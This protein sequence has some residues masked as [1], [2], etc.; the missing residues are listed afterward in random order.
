MS[1]EKSPGMRAL[2][3]IK[4]HFTYLD[5]ITA[6]SV[7]LI[8]QLIE[9]ETRCVELLDDVKNL[10]S[11]YE[12]RGEYCA[13]LKAQCEQLATALEKMIEVVEDAW[14]HGAHPDK[15]GMLQ[16]HEARAALAAYKKDQS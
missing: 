5:D 11:A 12:A 1:Q 6:S 2:E 10:E 7:P 8:C 15:A 9:R 3:A 16:R 14:V 4:E 13:T